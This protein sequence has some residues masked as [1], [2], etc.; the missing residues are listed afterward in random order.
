M[1]VT[2]RPALPLRLLWC[3]ALAFLL[4]AEAAAAGARLPRPVREALKAADI[5][6]HSVGVYVRDVARPAP[7]LAHEAEHGMNPA[8]T[9]KLVT[10]YAAL[11]LLGPAYAWKTEVYRRGPVEGGVLKGDLILKGY[12]DPALTLEKFW[13]LLREVRLHGIREIQG[14]LVLDGSH[15]PLPPADPGEFDN[16]PYRPYN[17]LPDALLV[18]FNTTVF[19]LLPDPA[20]NTV[21]VVADLGPPNLEVVNALRATEG[22]CGDWREALSIAVA[23]GQG[24]KLA[25]RLEGG[26]PLSCKEQRLNLALAGDHAWVRALFRQLWGEL[27]GTL[28]GGMREGEAPPDAELVVAA[29]SKPLAE[30]VRDINKFS[31]NVMARQL[32]LTL[33]TLSGAAGTPETGAEVVRQWLASRGLV[34]SELVIENGSGLSRVERISPEHLGRLLVDAYHSGVGPEFISSLPIVAVDGTMKKRLNGEAVAGRARIKTG[35]LKGVKAIAGYV[36]DRRD[37]VTAV[38]CI[39]NHPRA[40]AGQAAQDALLEWIYARP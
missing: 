40:A 38:V 18:N 28:T 7:L 26:F 16:E 10:T 17:A 5:P 15:F 29:S 22:P 3:A 34:S 6:E 25:V 33:G 1:P 32:L 31:N 27:G 23:V 20:K 39:I 9:M 37:R 35:S 21:N 19:R 8:S 30:V 12:G 13:L 2:L 4:L 24:G 11:D 36:R 14:D